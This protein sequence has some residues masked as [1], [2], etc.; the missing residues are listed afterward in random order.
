MYWPIAQAT[1]LYETLGLFNEYRVRATMVETSVGEPPTD[2]S[3]LLK[4]DQRAAETHARDGEVHGADDRHDEQFRPD[5]IEA[6]R[7]IEDG[8]SEVNKMRCGEDLH[9]VLQPDRHGLHWRGGAGER[10]C[11]MTR[12]GISRRPNWPI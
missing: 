6:S 12:T 7:P 5:N 9:G 4:N 11:R 3:S 1:R 2:E 10:I 8:L